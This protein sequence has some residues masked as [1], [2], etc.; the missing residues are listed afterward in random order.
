MTFFIPDLSWGLVGVVSGICAALAAPWI[1]RAFL[2]LRRE[3]R[4]KARHDE[5]FRVHG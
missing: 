3:S 2:T 1:V 5:I 4:E